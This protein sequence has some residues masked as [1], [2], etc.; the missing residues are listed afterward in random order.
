[1]LRP[2]SGAH[3]STVHRPSARSGRAQQ[4]IPSRLPHARQVLAVDE[5]PHPPELPL[6]EQAENHVR[7]ADGSIRILFEPLRAGVVPLDPDA[8]DILRFP[9]AD[10]AG[11]VPR[12]QRHILIDGRR[13][14]RAR[15]RRCRSPSPRTARGAACR[16]VRRRRWSSAS[17]GCSARTPAIDRRE[18][19]DRCATRT[20]SPCMTTDRRCASDRTTRSARARPRAAARL[21]ARQAGGLRLLGERRRP[22]EAGSDREPARP[23]ARARQR[24]DAR[25]EER[26][27]FAV[28]IHPAAR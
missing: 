28:N 27:V 25:T 6:R 13:R 12:R 8:A 14:S 23:A 7:L 19:G 4:R 10:D 24:R 26:A 11:A 3:A 15:G 1:M 5:Q 20:A 16:G 9:H 18:S 17:A 22:E 2:S 21:E